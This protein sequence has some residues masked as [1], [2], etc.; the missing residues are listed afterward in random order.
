MNAIQ[1]MAIARAAD[2]GATRQGDIDQVQYL[3]DK[4][5]RLN[6]EAAAAQQQPPQVAKPAPPVESDAARQA[7]LTAMLNAARAGGAG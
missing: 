1:R 7:R 2:A 3:L 4:A 6:S 5:A